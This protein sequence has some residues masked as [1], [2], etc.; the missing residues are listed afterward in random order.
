MRTAGGEW[1]A[2]TME[3]RRRNK[4]TKS[5][6]KKG[7]ATGNCSS[8]FCFRHCC[9]SAMHV[10]A[11][12][13]NDFSPFAEDS[14]CLQFSF[15]YLGYSLVEDSIHKHR[16]PIFSRRSV[17]SKRTRCKKVGLAKNVSKQ[18]R[19]KLKSERWKSGMSAHR[20]SGS[21][22]ELY[23]NLGFILAGENLTLVLFGFDAALQLLNMLIISYAPTLTQSK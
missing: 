5:F 13:P 12:R 2:A 11:G 18:S 16:Q 9:V 19:V 22:C 20:R 7:K 6:Q 4:G 23:S 3:K 14:A 17:R 8:C 21:W 10:A 15:T 1:V